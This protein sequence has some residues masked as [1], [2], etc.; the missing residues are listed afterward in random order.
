MF[1]S[2]CCHSTFFVDSCHLIQDWA[3]GAES[4]AVDGACWLGRDQALPVSWAASEVAS[5]AVSGA[6]SGVASGAAIGAASG[7][8][9]VEAGN[10]WWLCAS[11]HSVV[12]PAIN[13]LIQA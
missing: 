5:G 13:H 12:A 6:A 4:A 11:V 2:S 9:A 8:L 10:T 3:S 7:V 1:L